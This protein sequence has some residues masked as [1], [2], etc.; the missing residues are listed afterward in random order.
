MV[1]TS[2]VQVTLD[3]GRVLNTAGRWKLCAFIH[4]EPVLWCHLYNQ[5]GVHQFAD[6]TIQLNTG[7]LTTRSKPDDPPIRLT[8]VSIDGE[9]IL[10][11]RTEELPDRIGVVIRNP[12]SMRLRPPGK[13][14][15]PG[16]WKRCPTL[17]DTLI[18]GDDM[19]ESVG[20]LFPRGP[21]TPWA[22]G[23]GGI[24]SST[25]YDCVTPEGTVLEPTL[26]YHLQLE[27]G[28]WDRMPIWCID[29]TSGRPAQL[30]GIID[31]DLNSRTLPHALLHTGKTYPAHWASHQI[32]AIRHGE[33]LLE[34]TTLQLPVLRA[35]MLAEE[36]SWGPYSDVHYGTLEPHYVG[37]YVPPS[38]VSKMRMPA[39]AGHHGSSREIGWVALAWARLLQM[40]YSDVIQV[41]GVRAWISGQSTGALTSKWNRRGHMM[42]DWLRL[43]TPPHGVPQVLEL[44]SM[45]DKLSGYGGQAFEHAIYLIGMDALLTQLGEA[46]NDMLGLAASCMRFYSGLSPLPYMYNSQQFGPPH[47]VKTWDDETK[48]GVLVGCSVPENYGYDGDPSHVLNAMAV[49][50]KRGWSGGLRRSLSYDTPHATLGERRSALARRLDKSWFAYYEGEIS[51]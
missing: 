26:V 6:G 44:S 51:S 40:L 35:W 16:Q 33:P 43:V 8:R 34:F 7:A 11:D 17:G 23:G 10:Y 20:P 45:H 19:L 1:S 5:L 30:S 48:R 22:H 3:D 24:E 2:E 32:R 31:Y 46:R 50:I 18:T 39:H 37:E 27:R 14:Y 4:N 29:A 47:F 12:S 42:V 36:C 49:G 41:R 25:G 28:H 38:L 13:R 9:T 21:V 15:G